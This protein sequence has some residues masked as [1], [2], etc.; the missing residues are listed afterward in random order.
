MTE[1]FVVDEYIER[2]K[3]ILT[4]RRD[5]VGMRGKDVYR[6]IKDGCVV[7]YSRIRAMDLASSFVQPRIVDFSNANANAKRQTEP[8]YVRACV[9]ASGG[10]VWYMQVLNWDI[11]VSSVQCPV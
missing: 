1:V 3:E 9:D 11:P 7:L 8:V 4:Q 10:C 2:F 5:R 6:W